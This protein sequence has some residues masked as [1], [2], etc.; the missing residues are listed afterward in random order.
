MVS[1]KLIRDLDTDPAYNEIQAGWAFAIH[2]G[3]GRPFAYVSTCAGLIN[4]TSLGRK[5]KLTEKTSHA[6]NGLGLRIKFE[7]CDD[8][9]ASIIDAETYQL[10]TTAMDSIGV[11][12]GDA[13]V[14]MRPSEDF[15][16]L[17]WDAKAAMLCL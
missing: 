16:V 3:P 5:F 10:T 13:G 7:V 2:I 11:E 6:A 8:F 1:S 14:P 12:H 9:A 4:C 15:G 17:G